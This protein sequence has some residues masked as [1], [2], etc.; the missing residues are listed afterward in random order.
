[1]IDLPGS[2]EQL[3]FESDGQGGFHFED[4][5]PVSNNPVSQPSNSL[6][7]LWDLAQKDPAYMELYLQLL[8]ERENTSNAQAWYEKMS[9]SQY[10]R[11]VEDLKKAGL[12]PW[13]AL[14]GLNGAGSGSVQPAGTWSNSAYSNK[15]NRDRSNF[16]N[17][18]TIFQAIASFIGIAASIALLAA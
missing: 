15:T 5:S 9:G 10:Q 7:Y 2:P 17:A 14:Q 1:M 12:N 11:S 3:G 4:P 8:A 18:Q 16:Q 13:L 6:D